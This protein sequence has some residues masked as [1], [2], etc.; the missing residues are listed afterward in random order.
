MVL[1]LDIIVRPFSFSS[2]CAYFSHLLDSSSSSIIIWLFIVYLPFQFKTNK[3]HVLFHA[4]KFIYQF[5]PNS[6]C[7]ILNAQLLTCQNTWLWTFWPYIIWHTKAFTICSAVE[8]QFCATW[9]QCSGSQVSSAWSHFG[10]SSFLVWIT[11][12]YNFWSY[13]EI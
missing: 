13:F 5:R 9:C 2:S 7:L 4:S 8:G 1:S 3:K 11:S 6:F 12:R 10:T